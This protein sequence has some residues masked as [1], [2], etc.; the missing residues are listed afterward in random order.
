M[1]QQPDMSH[2]L[3]IA[4]SPAGQKLL[5]MLQSKGGNQ[6]PAALEKAAGGDYSDAKKVLTSLL[7]NPDI[8][9]LVKQLEEHT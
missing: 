9:T 7:A 4:Q 6:L 5:S 3:Q 8:Q 1:Q 2:L